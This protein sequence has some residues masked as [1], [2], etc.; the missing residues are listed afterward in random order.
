M[1]IGTFLA[2]PFGIRVAVEKAG[3]DY[4]KTQILW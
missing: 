2:F 1:L 3:I 4:G